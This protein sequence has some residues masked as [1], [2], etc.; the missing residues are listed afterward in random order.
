MVGCYFAGLVTMKLFLGN[1]AFDAIARPGGQ[2]GV[3]QPAVATSE[4]ERIRRQ[5]NRQFK[6]TAPMSGLTPSLGDRTL[7]VG[8]EETVYARYCAM[9]DE[10]LKCGGGIEAA[11][12][13]Y[14]LALD[15]A[16]DDEIRRSSP[17]DSWLLAALRRER[18]EES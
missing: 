2:D 12:E 3:Q 17:K 16:T 14:R 6:A 11:A 13:C 18:R 5:E 10:Y 4:I 15:R 1:A 9:G 8:D 7:D